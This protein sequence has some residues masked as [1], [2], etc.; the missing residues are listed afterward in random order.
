MPRR[1]DPQSIDSKVLRRVRAHG[2]GWV[3][4]PSAFADLGRPTAIHTAL[5]RHHKA[6]AIRRL[7]H[8]VYDYPRKHARLGLL[9]PTPDAV[10]R[11][12]QSRDAGKLQPAGA[13]AA[14]RL[15]LSEQVP[16]RIEYL[17]DGRPRTVRIGNQEIVLKRRGSRAMATADRPSGVVIRALEHLG[18]AAIN[19]DLVDR[20]K[21]Q[22][23]LEQRRSMARDARHAPAW[24]ADVLRAL[25]AEEDIGH[26]AR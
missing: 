26:A 7:A 2:P 12:L 18:P 15:G 11:A 19:R 9:S 3:F 8:G 4:T 17:T 5:A 23:T 21:R 10:A 1:N 20:L 13:Y 24:I 16:T 25:A 14:N 6:G 22:F